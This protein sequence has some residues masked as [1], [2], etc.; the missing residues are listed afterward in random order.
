MSDKLYYHDWNQSA[1][2]IG[3]GYDANYNQ[4]PLEFNIYAPVHGNVPANKLPVFDR[5]KNIKERGVQYHNGYSALYLQ[6]EIGLLE[7]KLRVTLAGRRTTLKT[8][9]AYSGSYKTSK[10]TPRAG[11]S[12]SIV[13]NTAGYFVYDE[14]FNEN[15]GADWQG[16]SFNPQ[17]GSNMELGLKRDWMN[18]KWNSVIAVYQITKNNV[19]TLDAEHSTGARQFSKQSGQQKVKGAELDIRGQLIKNVDVVLNYAFTEAKVSKDTDPKVIGNQVAG[20]SRHVQNTWVNYKVDRGNLTGLGI[21]LGYQYQVKRAPWYV[22]DN[23][24]KSLPDYFRLD[25]S[26]SYQKEKISF[27]L[28]VNNIL[29]KYLYS[30]GIYNNFYYWQTEPGTNLR[31]TVGYKF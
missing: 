2:L 24:E 25:G 13:K 12:Y 4:V 20:T 29:N 10:F 15:Y 7:N 6:D 18:G 9:N 31:L 28:V 19:L 3:Y 27:N 11:I 17:T 22:F 14:A 16:K 8:S 21:S 5:S 26:L 30:G 23:T 1:A